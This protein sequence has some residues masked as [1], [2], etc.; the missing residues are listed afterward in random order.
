MT[1]IAKFESYEWNSP[2]E[3]PLINYPVI[4]VVQKRTQEYT[5]CF[6]TTAGSCEIDNDESYSTF[7]NGKYYLNTGWYLLY[8]N[9]PILY[10][11]IDW[12]YFQ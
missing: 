3:L 5:L 4:A 11:I 8:Q 10:P 2:T 1:A 7:I 6:Y 12:K 9:L